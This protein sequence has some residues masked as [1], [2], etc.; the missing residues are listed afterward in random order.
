MQS[1]GGF[2]LDENLVVDDHVHDLPRKRCPAKVNGD[3]HLSVDAVAHRRQK[4]LERSR[5]NEFAIPE[6]EL[7]VSLVHRPN[8]VRGQLT[9]QEILGASWHASG[10][11]RYEESLVPIA[12]DWNQLNGKFGCASDAVTIGYGTTSGTARDN[13]QDS[14]DLL[15]V[16]VS[17]CAVFLLVVPNLPVGC[18]VSNC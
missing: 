1:F 7:L 9:F 18:P 15:L 17:F 6:S 12:R 5:V 14:L 4:D 2:D 8:N 13:Q 10:S 3:C 11:H 16:A